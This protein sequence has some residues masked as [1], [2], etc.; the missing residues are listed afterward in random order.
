[1]ANWHAALLD[2]KGGFLHGFAWRVLAKEPLLT[3][4]SQK[5]LKNIM[6]TM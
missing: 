3:C 1:M 5:A 2:V 4:K 6:K